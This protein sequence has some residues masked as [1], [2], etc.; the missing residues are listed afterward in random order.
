M[1][2][3]TN[4]VNQQAS[5]GCSGLRLISTFLLT[6][7]FITESF[8]HISSF[9]DEVNLLVAPALNLS[10]CTAS[11]VHALMVALGLVAAFA[12]LLCLALDEPNPVRK[13]ACL[14]CFYLFYV[15]TIW[16]VRRAGIWFWDSP[17]LAMAKIQICKNIAILGGLLSVAAETEGKAETEAVTLR[18]VFVATRPWSLSASVIPILISAVVAETSDWKTLTLWTLSVVSLQAATNLLN[19]HFDFE[20]GVDIKATA[21]DR[22]VVDAYVGSRQARRLG[23]LCVYMS[24]LFFYM[25]LYSE[26]VQ[27]KTVGILYVVG[28][29]L[30]LLYSTGL[31]VRGLGDLAVFLAFGPVLAGSTGWL[32]SG[33]DV[34]KTTL[35]AVYTVPVALLVVNIL[36]VNNVRDIYTDKQNRVHTVA[37]RL[38]KAS[39]LLY[40]DLLVFGALLSAVLI[41]YLYKI[42]GGVLA[43][44]ALPQILTLRQV[45]KQKSIPRNADESA[46]QLMVAFGVFTF[47]GLVLE[48]RF[49]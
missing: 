14:L 25:A 11:L 34:A 9:K 47:T 4:G 22:T 8:T 41:S 3:T 30:A 19:S 33:G 43:V 44:A 13:Y 21:G 31:K 10:I 27:Y 28:L 23:E 18:R 20:D 5:G 2:G 42:Y 16:W 1:V 7:V 15:T 12:L 17:D 29:G 49:L 38:G 26:D 40:M 48:R 6:F 37:V 45:V 36:H 35:A 32:S 24:V 46:A 39:S